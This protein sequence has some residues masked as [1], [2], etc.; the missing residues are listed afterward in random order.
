MEFF[1]EKIAKSLYTEFG[2]SL[3]THCLVFPNIRAGLFFLKYL[4]AEIDKPV[5]TPAIMSI[6]DLFR[7]QSSLRPADNE[8]LLF[9]LYKVYRKIKKSHESFDDFYFW[10]DMLLND[11]DDIDKYL[12][13]ASRVFRNVQ[14]LKKID[15]QFGGLTK[16]QT[17][18]IRRFWT[19]VNPEK[20]TREKAGFLSVW[21]ILTELYTEFR[22]LLKEKKLGYEGMIFR[23]VVE[24]LNHKDSTGMKWEVVHFIG[25]NALNECEKEIMTR[26]KKEGKARFYWDYD[27]SYI[28]GSRLNSAGY[29]L[30]ANLALFGNN[31]PEDWNYDTLLSQNNGNIKRQT[32]DTS[33]DVGQVKLIPELIADLTDLTDENAHET[34]VILADE[35]LLIPVLSSLPEN[36]TDINITMGY[37]LRHTSVYNLVRRLLDLQHRARK[38]NGTLLFN[39]Q[40]VIKVLKD[41]LILELLDEQEN[42]IINEITEKNLLWIPS[43]ILSRTQNLSLFFKKPSSPALLSAY[44]KEILSLIGS[45]ANAEDGETENVSVQKKIRNEFIYSVIL[46]LNRLDAVTS[47]EEVSLSVETW[48]RILDRLLRIQSVPFSGE[49]LSG[50]QI[51][52][53]LESR[54]LDFKNIIMLSVNE[55]ILPA[56]TVSSSFIPFTLREAF[57]LPSINHQE[58]IYA[59]HFYRL[60]HRAENVTF[61]YNS[62]SEGLKSGEVSRFLLQMK[63]DPVRKP[64]FK[65][66]SFVIKNQSTVNTILERTEEH[67]LRLI[68]RFT[69]DGSGKK[70]YFSPSAINTWLNCRMKFYYR[71]VNEL[72][73]KEKITEEIDPAMLGTLLHS[74]IKKLYEKYKGKV[75]DN[76]AL[77][78]LLINK[79]DIFAVIVDAIRENFKREN[80]SIVAVNELIIRDVL[81]VF[82]E[83]ILLR[84]KAA[85][86]LT[87][88]SFENPVGFPVTLRTDKSDIKLWVGGKIDRVDIKGGITRIIDYKTGK[89]SDSVNSTGALFEDDR[90]KELDGW[91]QTLLY[92]EAYLAEIPQAVVAPAVYKLKKLQGDDL[93]EKLIF[94]DGLIVE[95]Y[96]VVRAEFIDCLMQTIGVIF[97]MDE[98]FVMTE[99][100]WSKCRFCPYKKLCQ[101]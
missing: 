62:D 29:F 98:P 32:I 2:N 48:S 86:P 80:N 57:G 73:E 71:Y 38:E 90:D 8:I 66:L 19:N 15:E 100:T 61:L 40:D 52:G 53:I 1:L 79:R 70:K 88:L 87:I 63:Y 16:E 49:P 4:A 50:I 85:A 54:T 65:N 6:N 75:L 56:V 21:A 43:D 25:F 91:L 92:C 34:A 72:E 96:R 77:D 60:L 74:A 51:M 26:L 28:S 95:D 82:I 17:E 31:M 22:S 83:R 35:N 81:L 69:N 46:S 12:A 7:S 97:G 44:L 3:S 18:I 84:D 5:W 20:L 37:P 99:D 11:F 36:I 30:R 67:N 13:D 14:E 93:S 55:G 33:S 58:S 45:Q 23:D 27:N 39:H 59:Y 89:I 94:K 41:S 10:G 47:G 9:E 78:A 101:R 76:S 64:E 24:D 68:S 42:E